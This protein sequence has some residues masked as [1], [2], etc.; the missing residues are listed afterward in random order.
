MLLFHENIIDE[1]P[2][3]V[4]VTPEGA[5]SLLQKVEKSVCHN[6]EN[7][8]KFASILKKHK[9]TEGC[10]LMEECSKCNDH[11]YSIMILL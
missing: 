10:T 2:V 6:H 1:V 5:M 11:D 8:K 7:L 4:Q 9:C 3:D